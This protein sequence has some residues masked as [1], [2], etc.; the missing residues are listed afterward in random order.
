MALKRHEPATPRTADADADVAAAPPDAPAP[1]RAAVDTI[2]RHPL[3][4]RGEV[5]PDDKQ[6]GDLADSFAK[7]GVLQP[8]LVVS[9]AA[10]ER[11]RPDQELPD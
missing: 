3:N 9:R 5:Q 6:V 2:T 4:P 10:F 7:V 8:L 1:L 11:A